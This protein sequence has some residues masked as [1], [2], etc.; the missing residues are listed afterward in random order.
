MLESLPVSIIVGTILGFL[1][2]LGIGGGS[3]LLLWLTVVLGMDQNTAQGINLLFFLPAAAV[4][5]LFR[6]KTGAV[7][8]KK[9]SPAIIA[10]CLAALLFSWLGNYIQVNMMRKLFGGLLILTGLR[11]LTYRP[12][13]AR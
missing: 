12:R 2:G 13:K 9:I 4:S 1:A 10:G 8:L 6:W 5:I 7:D 3:L 11:E